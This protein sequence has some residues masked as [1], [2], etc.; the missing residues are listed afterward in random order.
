M[1]WQRR[2]DCIPVGA[3]RVIEQKAIKAAKR[4]LW[5][6][7][8]ALEGDAHWQNEM[9]AKFREHLRSGLRRLEVLDLPILDR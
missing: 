3:A 5:V 8:K 7:Q 9:C 1:G 6:E 2:D 4:S